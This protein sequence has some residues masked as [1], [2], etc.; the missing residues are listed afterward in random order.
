MHVD[1]VGSAVLPTMMQQLR[2]LSGLNCF[3]LLMFQQCRLS[4][5]SLQRGVRLTEGW[6]TLAGHASSS[7]L[8]FY[9]LGCRLGVLHW[10]SPGDASGGELVCPKHCHAAGDSRLSWLPDYL[11]G[12]AAHVAQA[13]NRQPHCYHHQENEFAGLG[14]FNPEH[15]ACHLMFCRLNP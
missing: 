3:Q 7:M 9:H 12:D 15:A 11:L 6:S 1:A 8:L 14:K 5:A 13:Q 10:L 2:V 4:N